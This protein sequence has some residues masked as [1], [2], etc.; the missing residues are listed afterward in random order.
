[1]YHV[2]KIKGAGTTSKPKV[3]QWLFQ[4]KKKEL[5]NEKNGYRLSAFGNTG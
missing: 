3:L 4:K 1:M 5:V 2:L